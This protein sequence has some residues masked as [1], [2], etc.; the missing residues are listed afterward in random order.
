MAKTDQETL[1][2]G[3]FRIRRESSGLKAIS[4]RFEGELWHDVGKS[5]VRRSPDGWKAIVYRVEDDIEVCVERPDGTSQTF[6]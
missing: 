2:E 4:A 6:C 1:R 3:Y 5:I